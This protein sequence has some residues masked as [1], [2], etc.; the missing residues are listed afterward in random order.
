VQFAVQNSEPA[1]NIQA[2]ARFSLGI[3]LGTTNS[4]VALEELETDRTGMVEI[5]QLLGPNRIG[6]KLTLPSAVYI[7]HPEEFPEEQL[8][9]PWEQKSSGMI[10]GHFARDH[11]ALVPDRLITSA[12]S[13]LSNFHIDP[14]KPVL[15]WKADIS[16]PKVS[17]LECSRLYLEHMKLGFLNAE[18]TQG[19]SWSI[20]E[21]QVVITVPASFDEVARNLTLEAARAAGFLDGT[22]RIRLAQAGQPW[23]HCSRLRRRR[24][25]LGFQSDRDCRKRGEPRRRTD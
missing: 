5:T 18:R 1:V 20:D 13:W 24:R 14:R 4:A 16:E 12:K 6:E 23:R 8:R 21:G 15:P 3:D 7:P 22:V 10:V 2:G 11:G 9:L 25:H 17:P 19:R